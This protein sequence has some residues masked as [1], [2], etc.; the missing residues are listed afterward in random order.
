[1]DAALLA[2]PLDAA[3]ETL[4]S[5]SRSLHPPERVEPEIAL[6]RLSQSMS[7]PK[8]IGRT[9]Q[10]IAVG[11]W[12]EKGPRFRARLTIAMEGR[13]ALLGEHLQAIVASLP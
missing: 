8:T 9:D 7:G 6:W 2:S 5:P 4:A 10:E 1:V 3:R 13:L 11:V 12:D